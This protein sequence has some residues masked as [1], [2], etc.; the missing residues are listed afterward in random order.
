M[1]AAVGAA[2]AVVCNGGCCSHCGFANHDRSGSSVDALGRGWASKPD[3]TGCA[4]VL[5]GRD[6]VAVC[7][8]R[9]FSG[10]VQL[11]FSI[12]CSHVLVLN[13]SG[14]AFLCHVEQRGHHDCDV[15]SADS[16]S[17]LAPLAIFRQHGAVVLRGCFVACRIDRHSGKPV[18]VGDSVSGHICW[19]GVCRRL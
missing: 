16:V 19:R 13:R 7:L 11:C 14:A 1:A 2:Y 18:V 15:R 17:G 5:R 6:G 9:V 4:D 10:C 3:A 12:C 8:L